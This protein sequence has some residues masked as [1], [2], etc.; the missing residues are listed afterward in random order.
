MIDSVVFIYFGGYIFMGEHFR[1]IK[2]INIDSAV[3][4]FIGGEFS[5]GSPN[6]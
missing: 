3:N 6:S 5:T 4:N 2:K 1:S